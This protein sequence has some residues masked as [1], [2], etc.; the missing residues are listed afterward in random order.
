MN[1]IPCP[2]DKPHTLYYPNYHIINPITIM[3]GDR[4]AAP[5]PKEEDIYYY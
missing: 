5:R 2:L 3:R 4:S 1:N